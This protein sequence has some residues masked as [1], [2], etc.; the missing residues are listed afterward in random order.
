MSAIKEN[1]S[2][3]ESLKMAIKSARKTWYTL[4]KQRHRTEEVK[5]EPQKGNL[6]WER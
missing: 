5:E 3:I 2:S 1:P 4:F 6:E